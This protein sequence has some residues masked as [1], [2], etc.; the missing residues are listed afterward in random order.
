[1]AEFDRDA[2]KENILYILK[3]GNGTGVQLY[4]LCRTV[5]QP[6]KYVNSVLYELQKNQIVEKVVESPPYWRLRPRPDGGPRSPTS[7]VHDA[8]FNRHSVV[9]PNFRPKNN[10]WSPNCAQQSSLG[11]SADLRLLDLRLF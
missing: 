4:N 1:M 6:K 7:V 8:S 9:R 10:F 2:L 3:S 5:N 11:R